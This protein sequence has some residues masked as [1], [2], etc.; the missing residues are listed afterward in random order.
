[1]KVV[2]KAI[3]VTTYHPVY[4]DNIKRDGS[5]YIEPKICVV[6]DEDE[7]SQKVSIKSVT[8]RSSFTFAGQPVFKYV[9]NI[10]LNGQMRICE[11]W[12]YV[13]ET[14]WILHKI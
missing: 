3:G 5:Y 14:K 9:C 10:P 4:E 1:M 2:N 13:K 7:G 8:S 12:Y 6:E 11:L